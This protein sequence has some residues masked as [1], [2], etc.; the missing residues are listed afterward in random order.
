MSTETT[1]VGFG[2]DLVFITFDMIDDWGGDASA[3]FSER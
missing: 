3:E 1:P 2:F